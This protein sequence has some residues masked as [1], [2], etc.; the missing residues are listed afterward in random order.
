MA[1]T[2]SDGDVITAE[3]LNNLEQ[4]ATEP[5]PKGDT[6]AQGPKGDAGPQGPKGD[7]GSQGPQG[8]QGPKGDAGPKGDTGPQGPAGKDAENQFTAEQ[9]S[10]LLALLEEPTV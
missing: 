1:H 10:A 7:T 8:E 9:V 4:K 6:G 2:W 3:L 5:G